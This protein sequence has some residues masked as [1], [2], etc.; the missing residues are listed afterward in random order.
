M[1]AYLE[2]PMTLYKLRILKKFPVWRTDDGG[3]MHT[4]TYYVTL[5]Y[6]VFIRAGLMI[7]SALDFSALVYDST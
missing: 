7:I 2:L 4:Y 3:A 1:G 6:L 5:W